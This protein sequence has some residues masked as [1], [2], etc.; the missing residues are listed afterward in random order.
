MKEFHTGYV[1]K[2][3]ESGPYSYFYG[4]VLNPTS[5]WNVLHTQHLLIENPFEDFI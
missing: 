5:L 3:R 1:S 4:F 2:S